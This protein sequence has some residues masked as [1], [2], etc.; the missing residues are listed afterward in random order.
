MSIVRW[1]KRLLQQARGVNPFEGEVKT[2]LVRLFARGRPTTPFP[3]LWN[4]KN[5]IRIF[6][7]FYHDA[8]K[9]TGSAKHN[10]YL[11]VAGA[12][13]VLLTREPA[14]I[15]AILSAT[16]DKPGQFD[17]D[18]SPTAGIARATGED[19]LLY[20]NGSIWR[21]QKKLAAK[22]FSRG[23]LFQPEEF[24]EF[25]ETFR[26][27]IAERLALLR[28]RQE[29]SGQK[30]TRIEL[31]PE[32]QAV[33]L[34]MLVNNFFGGNVSYE[35]LRER[36]VP[37]LVFLIKHMI[38]DTVAPRL[39]AIHRMLTGGNARL[40]QWQADLES[41]TDIALAGRKEGLG[42]WKQFK[43]DASDA[44]LRSNIRVF[45]AGALEA[46]TSFASWT[47]S[48]LS[49]LPELQDQICDEIKD[50]ETYDPENLSQAKLLNQSLEETLRLTPSL[51]FFPRKATVDTWIETSD[52]RKMFILQGTINRLDVWHANRC[53]EFWGK[54]VTGY[55]AEAFAPDR[56]NVLAKQGKSPKDILHFGF[57]YGPRVCPGKFLGQLEAGLVVG[58]FVKVFKF[59]AVSDKTGARAGV[60]TKPDDGVLV[61]LELR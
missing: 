55:P 12:P 5:P 1:S 22:P 61:D 60:T 19:S 46:T 51:Y 3:H 57:G 27:T 54:E 38:I 35:E 40:K 31:E 26:K 56:W 58:A 50:M 32:I 45:L 21:R 53:E 15:K 28:A 39:Y 47:I 33:M 37:A 25:E 29:E 11:Y 48:H 6:E 14:V 8:D 36:Y 49:R 2:S 52:H 9:E 23:T 41:L 34:E 30:V 18:T 16:G 42:S 17:R 44:A 20:S 24:H 4:Y 43:S 59:K 7:T 10:R 13:P